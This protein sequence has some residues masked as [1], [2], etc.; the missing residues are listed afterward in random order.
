MEIREN[1]Q[2]FDLITLVVFDKLYNATK[3]IEIE[4]MQIGFSAAPEDAD[5][6]QTLNFG[7]A[8]SDVLTWLAEEG[9]ITTRQFQPCDLLDPLHGHRNLVHENGRA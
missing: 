2:R 7:A 9:F 1:I 8:A 3:P 4:A 6:E 5:E